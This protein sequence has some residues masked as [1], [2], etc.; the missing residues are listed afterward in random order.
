MTKNLCRNHRSFPVVAPPNF[1]KI[2]LVTEVALQIFKLRQYL[3]FRSYFLFICMNVYVIPYTG[4]T[5][6]SDFW[7]L[8]I[9]IFKDAM[10]LFCKSVRSPN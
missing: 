7:F 9:A 8:T 5:L 3:I 6:I 2:T 4:V 1:L 10:P